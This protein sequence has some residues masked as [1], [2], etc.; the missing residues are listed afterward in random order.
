MNISTVFPNKILTFKENNLKNPFD[1][2]YFFY[3][4]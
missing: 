1:Y 3:I 2:K 4:A